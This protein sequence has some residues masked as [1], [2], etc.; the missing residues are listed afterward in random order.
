MEEFARLGLALD[1]ASM[2]LI[3]KGKRLV[4]LMKQPHSNPVNMISQII[5]LFGGLNGLFTDINVELLPIFERKILYLMN[6]SKI[7]TILNVVG[8]NEI[9]IE[10]T[11]FLINLLKVYLTYE[12]SIL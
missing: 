2:Y 1:E 11:A 5:L 8:R 3:E 7:F 12:E 10:L 6:N 9:S 4:Q